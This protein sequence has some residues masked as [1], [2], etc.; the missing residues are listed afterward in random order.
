MERV[1]VS[2]GPAPDLKERV[3]RSWRTIG[4]R[5]HMAL[6]G[7]GRHSPY[8][9]AGSPEHELQLAARFFRRQFHQS[10]ESLLNDG[11]TGKRVP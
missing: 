1:G 4:D 8:V 11:A 5:L 3:F 6:V 9:T 7:V 2:R 10:S